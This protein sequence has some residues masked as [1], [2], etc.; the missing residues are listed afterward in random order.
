MLSY[1]SYISIFKNT[2]KKEDNL[3]MTTSFLRIGSAK[4]LEYKI[5]GEKQLENR[6]FNKS[7]H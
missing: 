7:N 2:F 6:K 1:L 3:S 4:I 5:K